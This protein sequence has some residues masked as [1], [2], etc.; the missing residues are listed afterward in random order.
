MTSGDD[1]KGV[2]SLKFLRPWWQVTGRRQVV[3]S[4]WLA[5]RGVESSVSEMSRG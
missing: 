3:I 2:V 4:A 1:I 5:E